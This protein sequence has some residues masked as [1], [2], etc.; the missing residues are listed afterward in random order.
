MTRNKGRLSNNE[1]EETN[2]TK[3]T[4]LSK[5]EN[6]DINIWKIQNKIPNMLFTVFKD[7]LKE[8]SSYTADELNKKYEEFINKKIN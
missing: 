4:K 6:I 2:E 5:K 1:I 3:K 8:N 7:S